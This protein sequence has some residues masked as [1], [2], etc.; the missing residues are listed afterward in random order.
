TLIIVGSVTYAMKAK[1]LLFSSGIKAYIERNKRTREFG[2][3][4]G[5]YVPHRIEEAEQIL[6]RSGIKVLARTTRT[7]EKV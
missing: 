2:C 4:Y 1:D 7:A 5:L 3:G 6:L